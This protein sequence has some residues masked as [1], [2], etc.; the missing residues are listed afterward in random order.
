MITA[1]KVE[2]ITL[3]WLA[4]EFGIWP[5]PNIMGGGVLHFMQPPQII[6]R[7]TISGWNVVAT[8]PALARDVYGPM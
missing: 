2:R 6:L 3:R 8:L 1:C 7:R 5:E 4:M